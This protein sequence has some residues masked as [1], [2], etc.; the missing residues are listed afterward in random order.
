M[1]RLKKKG[2]LSIVFYIALI[3]IVGMPIYLIDSF[4][5][6]MCECHFE[7]PI[8]T[9]GTIILD[10][11]IAYDETLL[12]YNLMYGFFAVCVLI[13]MSIYILCIIYESFKYT[14]IK[15]LMKLSSI[16]MNR[17]S[18]IYLPILFIFIVIISIHRLNSFISE[19]HHI[20]LT[21][22]NSTQILTIE[23]KPLYGDSSIRFISFEEI[24]QI[25]HQ[26]GQMTT[27]T[28]GSPDRHRYGLVLIVLKNSTPIRVSFGSGYSGEGSNSRL[29]QELSA[30]TDKKL[31]IHEKNT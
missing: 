18:D 14:S 17:L 29:A 30:A 19:P 22:D 4:L 31:I 21:I 11:G 12:F 6:P 16:K 23:G 20:V 7:S 10:T 8:R 27:Y 15:P 26:H 3:L 5:Y 2:S 28:D 24:D 9:Q 25:Y 1:R 13:C